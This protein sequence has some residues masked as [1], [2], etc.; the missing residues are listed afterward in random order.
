MLKKLLILGLMLLVLL[1]KPA[2]A[3]S[4]RESALQAINDAESVISEMQKMEFGVTYAND[5]LNE[6]KL[7]FAQERYMAAET[8]AKSVPGIK[9]K[10]V[11]V[12]GLIDAAETRIYD[13]SSKGYDVSAAKALFN[14]GIAE[15]KI[16][17]YVGSESAMNQVL[18]S[19]DEAEAE[20][21]AKKAGSPAELD[22]IPVLLD[23]L[24]LII[25]LFLFVFIAGLRTKYMHAKRKL[26]K[27]LKALDAEKNAL[28]AKI[29]EVQKKYF[30]DGAISKADY[31]MSLDKLN[32]DLDEVKNEL[33]I[34]KENRH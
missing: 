32:R 5:T 24:W 13:L 18:N 25:I 27:R 10:A 3:E 23:N 16:D 20:E 34:L 4:T 17:N 12:S 7:L 2:S 21:S 19:L 30:K 1:A 28:S 26:K 11:K 14:S 29:K 6:A 8:V 31:E 9:D 22:I 33:S 15:F